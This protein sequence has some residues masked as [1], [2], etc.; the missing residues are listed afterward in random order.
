[1][2]FTTTYKHTSTQTT[3]DREKSYGATVTQNMNAKRKVGIGDS[4]RVKK[5]I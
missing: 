4:M 1:M 3:K 5:D 2:Q